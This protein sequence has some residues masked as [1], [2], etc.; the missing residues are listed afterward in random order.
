MYEAI[1]FLVDYSYYVAI[2]I[3]VGA[4]AMVIYQY[5]RKALSNDEAVIADCNTKI[6][7]TIVGAAIGLSITSFVIAVK[8]FY[9]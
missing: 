8:L 7:N 9:M 3:P 2:V 6:R 5:L 1:N 4:T